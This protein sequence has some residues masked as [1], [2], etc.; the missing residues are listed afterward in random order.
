MEN[1]KEEGDGWNYHNV[2]RSIRTTLRAGEC[3]GPLV[4]RVRPMRPHAHTRTIP[5]VKETPE[6]VGLAREPVC[7]ARGFTPR[8]A[9][10]K[11]G[12]HG[13]VQLL[14]SEEDPYLSALSAALKRK[15][16]L[17]DWRRAPLYHVPWRRTADE[18]REEVPRHPTASP[19]TPVL[20][21][22][23]PV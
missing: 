16:A 19:W 6:P 21:L 14:R 1:R 12:L 4:R 10:P 3:V 22:S 7:V 17:S 20:A 11:F 5:T 15:L 18:G 8:I 9:A 23:T 13:T 2:G